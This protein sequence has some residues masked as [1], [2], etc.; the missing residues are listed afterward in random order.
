MNSQGEA[1]PTQAKWIKLDLVSFMRH[2]TSKEAD[3]NE[4]KNYHKFFYDIP[5]LKDTMQ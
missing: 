5:M 1:T 4:G 2:M 3:T